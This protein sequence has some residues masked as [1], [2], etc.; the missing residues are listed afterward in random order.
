MRAPGAIQGDTGPRT[1][2]RRSG[3]GLTLLEAAWYSRQLARVGGGAMGDEK[4]YWLA[5]SRVGGICAVRFRVLLDAF[6]SI[7]AAWHAS[8]EALRGC[9][10]GPA[11]VSALVDGRTRI[12]PGRE[13]QRVLESG[14]TALT[15]LDDGYPERLQE[16]AQPPPV[17]YVRGTIE[18][19]DRWA[20]AVVGTRKPST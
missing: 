10:I 8:A 18:A 5:L 12:D 14:C 19:S 17:L 13:A 9:G 16:I 1:K 3:G 7:E 2:G 15:W 4:E 11:A 6:G 20:V